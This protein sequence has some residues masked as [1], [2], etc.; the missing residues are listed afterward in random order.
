MTHGPAPA[1]RIR[2]RRISAAVRICR[3]IQFCADH[4][5]AAQFDASRIP[6]RRDLAALEQRR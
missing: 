1:G 4:G 2:Q 6:L 5:V 3:L